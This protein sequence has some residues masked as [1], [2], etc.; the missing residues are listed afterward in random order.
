MS[1]LI[2]NANNNKGRERRGGVVSEEEEERR[3]TGSFVLTEQCF[4]HLVER[5]AG[6]LDRKLCGCINKKTNLF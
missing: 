2:P 3:G 5:E 4:C 1:R 6:P